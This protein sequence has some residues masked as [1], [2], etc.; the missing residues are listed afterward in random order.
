M[1]EY[2]QQKSE[3]QLIK[4][5]EKHC[6]PS[7]NKLF[8]SRG[9]ICACC[10][11]NKVACQEKITIEFDRSKFS[12]QD[13]PLRFSRKVVSGGC[14]CQVQDHPIK[15]WP[16]FQQ[17]F[18]HANILKYFNQTTKFKLQHT[19]YLITQSRTQIL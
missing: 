11:W 13:R 8:I 15:I 3:L 4:L 1:A 10:E 2:E 18:T 14:N 17:A 12:I 6:F 5:T 16:T 9:L 7:S 19:G